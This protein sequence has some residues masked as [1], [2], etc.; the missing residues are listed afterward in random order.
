MVG[1]VEMARETKTKKYGVDTDGEMASI[2]KKRR[3]TTPERRNSHKRWRRD[4]ATGSGQDHRHR[5]EDCKANPENR[6]L[7]NQ[8]SQEKSI[9][10]V[11]GTMTAEHSTVSPPKALK[12]PALLEADSCSVCSVGVLRRGPPCC[13]ETLMK[14][15]SGLIKLAGQ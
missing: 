3:R 12:A 13:R 15:C 10:T 7:H 4:R 6:T 1:R 9:T 5:L 8:D 14:A 11:I 2:F